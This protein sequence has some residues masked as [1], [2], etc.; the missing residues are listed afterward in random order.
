MM[1]ALSLAPGAQ[2]QEVEANMGALRGS[3]GGENTYTWSFGYRQPVFRDFSVGLAW[4]NEGHVPDHHRD[5]VALQGWYEHALLDPRLTIGLGA[6]PYR[7]YDTTSGG[8]R[9]YTDEHGWA[10]LYSVTAKWSATRHLAYELRFNRVQAPGSV[11]STSL[12]FGVV[13]RFPKNVTAPAVEAAGATRS[14]GFLHDDE[15]T[16]MAGESVVNSLNSESTF[17]KSVEYRHAFSRHIEGTVSWIDQGN[18]PLTSR[19]GVAAQVWLTEPLYQDRVV[20]GLGLGPYVAAD[21]YRISRDS[22]RTG[23]K[24]SGL[25]TM[26]AAYRF[27]GHWVARISWNRTVTDYNRDTDM[28]MAGVGYRF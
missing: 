26:S 12:L 28:F 17:A 3:G 6:G 11:D 8:F 15:L 23:A 9:P 10:M 22:S 16:V 25:L 24:L 5:G 20:L 19:N 4:L 13:Y 14:G 27:T 2:A 18:T 21:T 7:Y 1:G